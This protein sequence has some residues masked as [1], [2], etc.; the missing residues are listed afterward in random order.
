VVPEVFKEM[1]ENIVFNVLRLHTI[2]TAALFYNLEDDLFHL[3]VGRLELPDQDQHHLPRVVV[4]VLGV[5]Q[6]DQIS[7]SLRNID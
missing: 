4:G 6:R 5:H 1:R 7:N 2:R 3:L